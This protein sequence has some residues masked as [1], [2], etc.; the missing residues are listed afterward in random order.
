MTHDPTT[1]GVR[2]GPAQ[3]VIHPR[4][5]PARSVRPVSS[6]RRVSASAALVLCVISALG[7]VAVTAGAA[8]LSAGAGAS[9]GDPA[10]GQ[11]AMAA[12]PT[13][14][15]ASAAVFEV[16]DSSVV[17]E[18]ARAVG[19]AVV[20]IITGGSDSD[21]SAGFALQGAG[22]GVIVDPSGLILTNRHVVGDGGS[23]TVH[24]DDGRQ[25]E[26]TLKGVDT[27][28]DLALLSIAAKGLPAATL[29]D[30]AGVEVG[31]LA[32][33]IGNPEGDLPGSVTAG[34]ISAL[35]RDLVVGDAAGIQAPESLRHL[36]QHDAAINPGNSGGP[37][38]GPDGTVIGINTAV[39]GGSQGIGF[40]IP[41]DLARP[42]V[43]QVLAGKPIR[44]PYIGIFFTE[45]D[46]QLA[47]ERDLPVASGVLVEGDTQSGQPGIIPDGPA[48]TAG[49]KE[50]DILT[51][52]DGLPIDATHQLDVALLAHEPGDTVALTVRRGGRTLERDVKLGVRPADVAQ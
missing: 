52:I 22:S 44:R 6:P 7:G 19:P 2:H 33:A 38:I 43:K 21:G 50:G 51:A 28:T 11:A 34:I 15:T 36:I 5:A 47:K 23:L 20:A 16:D 41:I 10:T 45:V 40:A 17:K 8:A 46:A 29:G 37:L 12:A 48:A 24:L 27:L 13:A 9:R 39:S 26:G 4:V 31:E 18:I 35:E 42:I 1:D 30:S 3:S 25:F 49:L 14:T 32:V